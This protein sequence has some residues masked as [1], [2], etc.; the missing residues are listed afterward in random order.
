MKCSHIFLASIKHVLH[1]TNLMS[2]DNYS[3][4]IEL[5]IFKKKKLSFILLLLITFNF[6]QSQITT[7]LVVFCKIFLH[8]FFYYKYT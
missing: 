3:L 4:Q 2:Y 6:V 7:A 8:I 5:P 1:D